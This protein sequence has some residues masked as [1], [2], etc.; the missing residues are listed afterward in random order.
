MGWKS[1]PGLDA[2]AIYLDT[3]ARLRMALSHSRITAQGQVS[4]P[5]TL[6][7]WLGIG[8]GSVLGFIASLLFTTVAVRI[9]MG[10]ALTPLSQ[11]L[12]FVAYPFFAATLFGWAWEHYRGAD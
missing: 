4:V 7:R 10:G 6:R 3:V 11:P 5:A 8:P 9:F 2:V 12:P 1:R